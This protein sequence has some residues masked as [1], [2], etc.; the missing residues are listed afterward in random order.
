MG[1]ELGRDAEAGGLTWQR[2]P[3]KLWFRLDL[4]H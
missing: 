4:P 1:G 2:G 3:D